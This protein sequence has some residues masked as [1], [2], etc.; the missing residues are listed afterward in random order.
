LHAC[1][2]FGWRRSAVH[3]AWPKTAMFG[4]ITGTSSASPIAFTGS[5]FTWSLHC[6]TPASVAWLP[7]G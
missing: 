4:R 7:P 1:T 6:E 3:V 2:I 5:E